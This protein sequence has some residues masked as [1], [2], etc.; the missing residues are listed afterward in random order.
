[1]DDSFDIAIEH[2]VDDLPLWRDTDAYALVKGCLNRHA[3]PEAQ[4][5]R[6]IAAYREHAHKQ[7]RRGLNEDIDA[8]LLAETD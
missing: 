1:M 6:L 7:R 4:F 2:E 8:I 5:A 3:V